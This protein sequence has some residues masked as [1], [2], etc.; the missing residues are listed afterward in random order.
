MSIDTNIGS[1]T[2]FVMEMLA[3]SVDS[4][5]CSNFEEDDFDVRL[6]ERDAIVADT[7]FLLSP[8]FPLFFLRYADKLLSGGRTLRILPQVMRELKEKATDVSRPELAHHAK[9][10]LFAMD[11]HD[12]KVLFQP[13]WSPVSEGMIADVAIYRYL[14]H[15]GHQSNQLLLTCDKNLT[16]SVYNFFSQEDGSGKKTEVLTLDEQG[17]PACYLNLSVVNPDVLPT[18]CHHIPSAPYAVPYHRRSRIHA[19]PSENRKEEFRTR[20]HAQRKTAFNHAKEIQQGAPELNL[21]YVLTDAVL[22]MEESQL[23]FLFTSGKGLN[24]LKHWE[25]S[26]V[27]TSGKRI[28][29]SSASLRDSSIE[30][31]V[32]A[33]PNMFFIHDAV[34]PFASEETA[35]LHLIFTTL[36]KKAI[37]MGREHIRLLTKN[38]ELY[39]RLLHR[40]PTCYECRN[41]LS[42]PILEDGY[43]G[44][45]FTPTPRPQFA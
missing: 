35:L 28:H 9:A 33:H 21:D 19:R 1:Q 40:R 20:M 17:C 39:R 27:E 41:L 29:V 10:V 45:M 6:A 12:Y 2:R 36:S 11:S 3:S 43:L 26:G 30:E 8:S 44:S 37:I 23:K 38:K 15:F 42:A 4:L 18:W 16:E 13:T 31:A 24:F 14:T 22:V 34:S 32:K 7:C 25:A 5:R